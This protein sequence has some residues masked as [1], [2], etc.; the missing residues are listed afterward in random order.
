MSKEEVFSIIDQLVDLGTLHISFTGG[1]IFTRPDIMDIIFHAKRRAVHIHLMTN[2]SLITEKLADRLISIGIGNFKIS[3]PGATKETF[4]R[5]TGVEGSFDKV[6]SVLKMLR[7][8]GV[9]PHAR[10][11]VININLEEV[12]SIAGLAR[13]MG[14][15]F[16]C[17]PCIIPRLD[18]GKEPL[19]FNIEPI[20]FL[21]INKRLERFRNKPFKKI[22]PKKPL[23]RLQDNERSGFW[24]RERLFNCMAGHTTA[25]INPYGEMKACMTV[26][27]PS[28]DIKRYGVK[29]CWE[30]TKQFVD[31]LRAPAGWGCF[32]CEYRDW[33]SWCPG[34]GYLNT[35][36]V[37]GCPP[38]QKELAKVR[39]ARYESMKERS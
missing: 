7:Q 21:G 10:T 33:C 20:E 39:K 2:G 35:G 17:S 38:Y 36:D 27:E 12:A 15:S 4:D 19:K 14:A 16:S 26:P 37:F 11:C 13:E 34:R 30:K 3:L 6:V 25:F 24:E 31:T 1:E 9:I 8:K 23:K 18:L 28:F 22:G 5:I 32:S 29:E